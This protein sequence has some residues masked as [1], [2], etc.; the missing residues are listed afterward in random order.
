MGATGHGAES[1][2]AKNLG[3]EKLRTA[4]S[5]DFLVSLELRKTHTEPFL[6]C[7]TRKTSLQG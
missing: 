2:E 7:E 5:M 6:E 3:V 1:L 4:Q